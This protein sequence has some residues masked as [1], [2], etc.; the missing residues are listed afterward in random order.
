MTNIIEIPLFSSGSVTYCQLWPT[1]LFVCCIAKKKCNTIPLNS[2]A[3]LEENQKNIK[4]FRM[5]KCCCH[6]GSTVVS[7]SEHALTQLATEPQSDTT[8]SYNYQQDRWS[9]DTSTPCHILYI[10]AKRIIFLVPSQSEELCKSQPQAWWLIAWLTHE[11]HRPS[12]Y[13][14]AWTISYFL[15]PWAKPIWQITQWTKLLHILCNSKATLL[16]R[17]PRNAI[18]DVKKSLKS[19]IQAE[20]S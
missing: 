13:K 8:T 11:G 15:L 9:F 4:M 3:I 2:S 14:V 7:S 20:R 16:K 10:K 1:G 12:L 17:H 18:M 6:Q 19:T 5:K